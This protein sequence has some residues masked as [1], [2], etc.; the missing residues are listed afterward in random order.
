M[1][2][3]VTKTL[4]LIKNSKRP[5]ILAGM[6]IRVA[7]AY[8]EFHKLVDKLGIPV[9][10]ASCANDLMYASHR[11]YFGNP[12][13]IGDRAANFVIQNAD[14]VIGIG[15]RFNFKTI[16]FNYKAFAREAK[17]IAVDIDKNELNKKT[18]K[19]K[20]KIEADA[21]DFIREMII[22]VKRERLP[23]YIWWIRKCR[24]WVKK[25]PRLLTEYKK[26]GDKYINPYYFMHVLSNFFKKFN[27]SIP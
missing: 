17:I 8:E 14:L 10:T 13:L 20:L 22:Q 9:V 27:K 1:K 25:F 4:E 6:G 12:G 2:K 3:K 7:D 26:D 18:I 21:K 19:P 11:L 15:A 5:V 24:E 23:N 16:S